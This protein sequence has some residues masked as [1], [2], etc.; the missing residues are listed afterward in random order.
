V[1]V[2]VMHLPANALLGQQQQGRS[3]SAPHMAIMETVVSS[4]ISHPNLVQVCRVCR[5]GACSTKH[6]M[7]VAGLAITT[8]MEDAY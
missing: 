6:V 8:L 5:W 3:S 1:A 7:F 4:T 2:K